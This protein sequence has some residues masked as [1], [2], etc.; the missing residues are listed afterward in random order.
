[1]S[2]TALSPAAR[3]RARALHASALVIDGLQAAPMT[4]A[5]F[6]R[7]MRG[8]IHAVNY[9]SATITHDFNATTLDL[10]NLHRTIAE[11]SDL[12]M[13]VR[14]SDDIV[15]A[16]TTGRIGIIMGL[17]SATPVMND[18][19]FLEALYRLGVRIIQLTYNERNLIG[20]GCIERGNAG[21]SRFGIRVV[22]E[23]NRLGLIIDLSH[24]GEQTTLDAIERSSQPI[25]ITHANARALTPSPRNKSPEVLRRL[26]ANGGVIGAA[27]WAPMAFRDPARRPTLEDFC[28]HVERLVETAGIDHVGLGSDLGEGESREYYEGMFAKGGG[29]YPEVTHMLGD[30]YDFDRRMI[31]GLD[32]AITFPKVTEGLV[33]RGFTDE[34]V[35]KLLGE[36]L[37]R[38]MRQVWG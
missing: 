13:H 3:D 2:T 19:R 7:L 24:C 27:F 6:E 5:H 20:D 12:V 32:S 22:E 17:Q 30:W 1:M 28:D 36:N 8:G 23:M 11:H 37:L 33:A 38:V 31:E 14:T 26:E 15:T 21:L 18:V 29:L 4:P 9:T 34:Q 35:R 25:L 10:V 16:R